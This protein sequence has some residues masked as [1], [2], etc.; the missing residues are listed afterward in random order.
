MT[1]CEAVGCGRRVQSHDVPAQLQLLELASMPV[2]HVCRGY[3]H[4]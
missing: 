2:A 1:V 4:R 3:S